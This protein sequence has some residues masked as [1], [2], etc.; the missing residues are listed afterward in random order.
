MM[1]ASYFMKSSAGRWSQNCTSV[2]AAC[3][4]DETMIAGRAGHQKPPRGR[5]DCPKG[6]K[7]TVVTTE[8][9]QLHCVRIPGTWRE[10]I[11]RAGLAPRRRWQSRLRRGAD[12]A[13]EAA[14][15]PRDLIAQGIAWQGHGPQQETSHRKHGS[16]ALHRSPDRLPE[17]CK[18]CCTVRSP[19]F[20]HGNRHSRMVNR[21]R[22]KHGPRS[23]AEGRRERPRIS[24]WDW[25]AAG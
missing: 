15:A 20:G 21:L 13:V 17:K 3:S 1:I 12:R 11:L 6:R 25:I 18:H 5:L 10:S 4:V 2:A 16:R 24:K 22:S 19:F 9:K 7:N 23:S 8:P 14:E